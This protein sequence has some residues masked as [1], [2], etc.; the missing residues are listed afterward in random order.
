[1]RIN[2]ILIEKEI[3]HLQRKNSKKNSLRAQAKWATHGETISKYW[4][5]INSQKS[6]R[7]IIHRL[8]IPGT[9]RYT[10]KSEE[11]AEIAKTYHNGIQTAD[12]ER[13]TETDK[14]AARKRTLREIPNEQKLETPPAHMEETL[15]EEHILEALTSSKSGSAA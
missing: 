13:Q 7:D 3:S 1:M 14:E 5:K 6:P 15:R 9:E 12:N 8:N 11:M 2:E 4:S 10:T